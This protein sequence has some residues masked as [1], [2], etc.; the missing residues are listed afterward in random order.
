MRYS[1]KYHKAKK[2]IHM[3]ERRLNGLERRVMRARQLRLV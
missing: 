1:R 2:L 3:I